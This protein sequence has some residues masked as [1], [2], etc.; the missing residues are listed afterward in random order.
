M[1]WPL[2][3]NFRCPGIFA[4][5]IALVVAGR[6]DSISEKRLELLFRP[7]LGEQMALSTDGRYLAYT[8][9]G[10][11]ILNIVVMDL[12]RLETKVRIQ[13]DED[14]PIPHSK[15]KQR[16]TLRFLEWADGNRLVFAPTVQRNEPAVQP[17]S[18]EMRAQLA[19][20][21]MSVP[22]LQP[23]I[24]APVMAV[25][26]DGT[27]PRELVDA[28]QLAVS[29]LS[30]Q[31]RMRA[32]SIRGFEPGQRENLF[33]EV[34]GVE[35]LAESEMY[36][37]NVRTG[38]LARVSSEAASGSYYYDQQGRHRLQRV[39]QRDGSHDLLHRAPNSTRWGPMPLPAGVAPKLGFGA[40]PQTYFGE[41][42][43]P[44]GFDADP[45]VFVYAANIG[46][47]TFGIYGFNL[48]T[49]EPTSLVLEHP[50]RDLAHL[51]GSPLWPGVV[52][53][54]FTKA[55]LGVQAPGPTAVTVWVDAGLSALQQRLEQKFPQRRVRIV[56]WDEQRTC[57]LVRVLGPTDQGRIFLYR[58]RED[59]ATELMSDAPWLRDIAL[60]T[61]RFF[62]FN[63][64]DGL[65]L[66]GFLTLP[67]A[68]RLN[69]PP[70]IICLASGLP[71]EPHGWSS[72]IRESLPFD[73]QTQVLA[74]MGFIVCRLNNRGVLGLGARHRDALRRDLERGAGAD[75]LAAIEWIAQRHPIDRKRVALLGNGFAGHLA[76]R[77]TQ[78]HPET[79]R[80][81]VTFDPIFNLSAWVQ[82]PTDSFGP[83][84]FAEQTNVIY[85]GGDLARLHKL[86][87]TAHADELV[88]PVFIAQPLVAK[89]DSGVT[90]AAG[91]AALRTQLKRGGIPCEVVEYHDDFANGQ[92]VARARLYRR[93]EE[94]FN[95]N[96]YDP[97]VKIGPTRVVK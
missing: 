6:A 26:A 18:P 13:A 91:V 37:L 80:C 78:L 1:F 47:D 67:R 63:G 55:F 21:G 51:N 85:L 87:V 46:R 5:G 82:P 59:L 34:P 62:E 48:A 17:P 36:R 3:R 76:V 43:I 83:A 2:L 94:F 61:T 69:P 41:R 57:F 19:S 39:S 16:A 53:D 9:H 4:A 79:F 89:G 65:Q 95:L 77:A 42:L 68:P 8:Q 50:A 20:L 28:K 97:R 74:D 49:R 38:A 70:L 24:I 15:E 54:K 10:G 31:L 29:L 86:E 58:R 35:T 84:T 14:R 12:D 32:P 33:I 27:H 81:A 71:P 60:H 56:D 92:P 40:T 11:G 22:P 88:A 25:N 30:G 93:L 90:L 64:P 7:A 75:A 66:S 44:L 72:S 96:L 45:N 73:P 23:T 52:F